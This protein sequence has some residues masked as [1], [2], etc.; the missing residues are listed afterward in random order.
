MRMTLV[1]SDSGKIPK[2][3]QALRQ[4]G[5][6]SPTLAVSNGGTAVL[7]V[8]HG[9]SSAEAQAAISPNRYL[10]LAMLRGRTPRPER[11]FWLNCPI[12]VPSQRKRPR[13]GVLVTGLGVHGVM[14]GCRR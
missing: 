8:T 5:P 3:F 6:D 12:G 10:P 13:A 11:R 9:H 7:A 4:L 14:I 2:D 1:S